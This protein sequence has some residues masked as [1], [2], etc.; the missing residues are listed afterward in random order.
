M[1]TKRRRPGALPRPLTPEQQADA[2]RCEPIGVRVALYYARRQAVVDRTDLLSA[3]DEAVTLAVCAYHA[4]DDIPD[5]V[6]LETYVHARVRSTLKTLIKRTAERPDTPDSRVAEAG[7]EAL[8]EY[9]LTARDRGNFWQDTRAQQLDQYDDEAQN[10]AAALAVGGAGEMW[11]M[12]GEEG[13]VLRLEHGRGMKALHDEVARLAPGHATIVDMRFFQ[14]M[15]R[16]DVAK[17][18]GVSESTVFRMIGEAIPV[19]RA[20]LVAQH[21]DPSILDGR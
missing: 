12:R 19:L 11:H 4:R 10:G 9:A 7:S 15:K 21:V 6:P 13:L 8:D 17:N 5:D 3:A 16:S 20:R 2:R 14:G 1:A 18:A